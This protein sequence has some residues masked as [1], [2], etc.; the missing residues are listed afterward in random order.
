MDSPELSLNEDRLLEHMAWVRALARELVRD[1]GT[2]DDLAQ[3]TWLAF[4]R[5][6]PDT[7]RPLRPWLARVLRNAAGLTARRGANRDAREATVA[8]P[9]GLPAG[10]HLV[11]RAEEQQRVARAV[12]ALAEPYRT[13]LLLRYYE[14]LQPVEIARAQ[15]IPAA[16]V[17]TRLFRGL[18]QVRATLDEEHGGDREAWRAMLL[19]LLPLLPAGRGVGPAL[20]AALAA[21]LVVTAGAVLAVSLR[22]RD[23]APAELAGA[24]ARTTDARP[25]SRAS[26]RRATRAP[27]WTRPRR[28][29][30]RA[31]AW[32]PRATARRS[33]TTPC[34]WTA[35][36]SSATRRAS[37][38]STVPRARSRRSTT[39][40]TR[41]RSPRATACASAPSAPSRASS[42]ATR[43]P[44]SSRS[45]SVRPT[46]SRSRR[47]SCSTSRGSRRA[48][49]P[50][51][52]SPTASPGRSRRC[53]PPTRRTPRRGCASPPR[54][55]RPR[56]GASRCATTR[57][58][59]SARRR[60]PAART[61]RPARRSR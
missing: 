23:A 59:C 18:E 29:R 1:P 36:S 37:S 45:R 26:R 42:S 38:R 31:C 25:R 50:R 19:P 57:A 20:G 28:P 49:V 24:G 2:A 33:T 9:E 55:A 30:R 32:S 16:T 5:A 27:R 60:C 8:R 7:D 52:T 44:P 10:D 58:T 56:P 11:E 35:A 22:A 14:G 6:R 43:R 21:G 3:E 53:A 4:L 39:R 15:E 61:T 13:T 34:A 46:R 47:R 40:A 17:R 51:W 12:L 41:R 48:C 54:R